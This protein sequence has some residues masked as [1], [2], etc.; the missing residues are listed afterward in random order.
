MFSRLKNEVG[1]WLIFIGRALQHKNSNSA[2]P[3]G[4]PAT[5]AISESKE[6][7]V[8]GDDDIALVDAA[9]SGWFR[10]ESQELIE[11]FPIVA[12]D[13]VLDVG[14]GDGQFTCF[15][16]NQGAEIMIADID[17]EKIA[18]LGKRLENSPARAVTQLV[19]DA[20]PLP[21]P[22]NTVDKVI[23]MEVIEHVDDPKIFLSEL[24]RVGKPGSMYLITAPDALAEHGQKHLAPAAYFEKPNH[25]RIIERSEFESWILDAGL[26]IIERKYY[27]FYKAMW[28]NFFWACKQD[29]S[30]PW[31]PLLE[32]WEKTWGLLLHTEDGARIKKGLDDFM[33]KSQGI[34]AIKPE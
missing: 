7:S 16:A 2:S 11:G 29:L 24:V 21:I 31:H 27:G 14:C 33:P 17:A 20:D 3:T 15:C 4:A 18:S 8:E 19:T 26:K 34:I 10:H 6:E 12:G 28:W 13:T 32:S 22:D 25:I 23:A 1:S 5:A 30:P 9:M